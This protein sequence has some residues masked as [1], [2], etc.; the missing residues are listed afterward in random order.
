VILSIMVMVTAG[1]GGTNVVGL[2]KGMGHRP[3]TFVFCDFLD[4]VP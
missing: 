2:H 3:T 1:V 4:I